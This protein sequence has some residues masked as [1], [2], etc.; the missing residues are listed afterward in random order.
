MTLIAYVILSLANSVYAGQSQMLDQLSKDGSL[1]STTLDMYT[2]SNGPFFLTVIGILLLEF[3]CGMLSVLFTRSANGKTE[4]WYL[5]SLVA[6][7]LPAIIY[8]IFAWN[9]WAN[10]MSQYES[11]SNVRP[12]EPAPPFLVIGLIVFEMAVC[13]LASAAGGWI[14]KVALKQ[15]LNN[16]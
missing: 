4:N 5:A 1:A 9:N 2:F 11:H 16:E 6:G 13:L 7:L 8:G 15:D 10:S 14:A 12:M 3:L